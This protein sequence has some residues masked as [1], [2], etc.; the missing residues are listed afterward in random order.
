MSLLDTLRTGVKIVDTVT[1]PIQPVVSYER[2]TGS[3]GYGTPIYNPVSLLRA[4]VHCN[5]R[6][7]GNVDGPLSVGR[8]TMTVRTVA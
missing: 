7:V 2:H 4:L 1:K 5:S 3:D 8:G 6:T